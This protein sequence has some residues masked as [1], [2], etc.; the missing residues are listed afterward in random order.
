M[1]DFELINKPRLTVVEG[2]FYPE[3]EE[4]LR[5][6][7]L[8]MERRNRYTVPDL[9][10]K[11]VIG[12]VLP[13]AGYMYSG[14]QC[15]PV[16]MG[17]QKAACRPDTV[18]ILHPNHTGY[19]EAC[20]L[21]PHVSWGNSLGQVELD[22]DSGRALGLPYHA[23]AH[24]YEH[25]AEVILPFLQNYLSGGNFR[26]LP[27]CMLDQ[28][29]SAVMRLSAALAEVIRDSE[30]NFLILASSDFSHYLAAD[31]GYRKDQILLDAILAKAPEEIIN[32]ARKNDISACGTGP[33]A[34]LTAVSNELYPGY[35]PELIARGHSG[36]VSPSDS[37][38]DYL[39]LIYHRPKNVV[40]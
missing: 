5:A 21:D 7:F 32:T 34:V 18:I 22:H 37:V 36:E 8:N 27:V 29:F 30:K 16:F 31:D 24:R 9:S 1:E 25:S 6:A 4:A 23:E 12:A 20:S 38:V 2:R 35:T 39:S 33:M 26:I 19:G 13:H 10:H 11:Q 3:G 14:W 17:L 28:G 40:K 15:I